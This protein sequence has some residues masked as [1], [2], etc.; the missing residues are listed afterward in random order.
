MATKEEDKIVYS[1]TYGHDSLPAGFIYR[2]VHLNDPA[3]FKHYWQISQKGKRLLSQEEWANQLHLLQR[4]GWEHC[5]F[6]HSAEPHILLL[7]MKMAMTVGKQV[8]DPTFKGEL[9][10]VNWRKL[11]AEKGE[12][13]RGGD[14]TP[15]SML[16]EALT[17]KRLPAGI[18]NS[19]CTPITSSCPGDTPQALKADMSTGPR[20]PALSKLNGEKKKHMSGVCGAEWRRK[21]KAHS[22]ASLLKRPRGKAGLLKRP[23]VGNKRR[24]KHRT[25]FKGC[26]DGA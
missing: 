24:R 12:N 18:P 1:H 14:Q 8:N 20:L 25:G 9:V 3:T 13:A 5:A 7:R 23:S 4:P 17:V 16:Q 15:Q 10:K 22:K 11:K 26:C 21:I 6:G 2:H 19:T